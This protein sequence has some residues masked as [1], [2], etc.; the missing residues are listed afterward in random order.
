MYKT[1]FGDATGNSTLGNPHTLP[2]PVV[3]LNEFLADTQRIG[4]GVVVGV[5]D[6]QTVLENNKQAFASEFV[7]RSRFTTAFATSMTPAQFVDALNVNAGNVL[8]AS[9]RTT[10][11]NLFGGAGNTAN[12]TAR[13]QA[14]RQVAEDPDLVANEINRA[15]VFMQYIGYLRRNPNDTPDSDYTGFDFWK[16]KLDAFS[17]NFISAEMVKAFNTSIEY[18]QR[19]GSQ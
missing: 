8:S 3:R 18:R 17:G 2:V 9:E 6:W 4:Q 5:G 13:A 1:A 14:V 12:Q 7:Q 11:I 19:F 15:F 16:Q 10:A